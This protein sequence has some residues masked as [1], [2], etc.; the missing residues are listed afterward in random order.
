MTKWIVVGMVVLGLFMFA[1]VNF[2]MADEEPK[3]VG[4]VEKVEISSKDLAKVLENQEKIL[5]MLEEIRENQ[6]E[7][8][9]EL[10]KIKYRVRR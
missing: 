9:A 1:V 3:A 4:K 5:K 7:I 10:V 6:K 2:A 8:K